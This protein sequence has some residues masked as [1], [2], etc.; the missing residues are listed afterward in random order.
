VL[1]VVQVTWRIGDR[2]REIVIPKPPNKPWAQNVSQSF[3]EYFTTIASAREKFKAS[4]A[5]DL[6]VY[7]ASA[8]SYSP[9]ESDLGGNEDESGG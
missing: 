2:Y 1:W 6:F 3:R 7:V 9:D 8:S 4:V 5:S